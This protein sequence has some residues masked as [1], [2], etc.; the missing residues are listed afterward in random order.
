MVL[1]LCKIRL[2]KEFRALTLFC[3]KNPC[4][5]SMIII[6]F[7]IYQE[8]LGLDAILKIDNSKMYMFPTFKTKSQTL[9]GEDLII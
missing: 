5:Y 9:V 1:V 7:G 4:C 2:N 6:C 3:E 8:L